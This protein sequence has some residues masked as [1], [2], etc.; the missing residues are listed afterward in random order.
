V[1]DERAI[2][3]ITDSNETAV[4]DLP[5]VLTEDEAL[6]A[7]ERLMYSA[8]AVRSNYEFTVPFDYL[9]LTPSDVITVNGMLMRVDEMSLFIDGM[10]KI[11]AKQEITSVYTNIS[12][13]EAT[14]VT[15]QVIVTPG[16]SRWFFINSPSLLDSHNDAGFYFA[17]QGYKTGWV[18]VALYQSIDDGSSFNSKVSI[19]TGVIGGRLTAALSSGPVNVWD[20][21]NTVEVELFAT[22]D[23]LESVTELQALN[24]ANTALI[25]IDG[26]WEVVSF[27][28]VTGG[29]GVY[30][31]S[32]LL[33]GRKGTDSNIN[34]HAI[35]DL[36]ILLS[37]DT[38]TRIKQNIDFA[39]INL[40]YKVPSLNT[41][42]ESAAIVNFTNTAMALKC[43]SPVHIKGVRGSGTDIVITWKRRTR[44]G[45]EWR[46][47][48][49]VS[50]SETIE[51]YEV[52]ILDTPDGT[53][54]RTL[55]ATAD[56]VGCTYTTAQQ[57]TD[58][59][60]AQASVNVVVY[61]LSESVGRGTGAIATI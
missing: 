41:S 52:D 48:T 44:I 39:N 61:Q 46:D 17:A 15:D 1:G 25:G 23:T 54:L 14:F 8:W 16:P 35:N 4:I 60:S 21:T 55:T 40:Q 31:L 50:L 20:K 36:F 47:L 45:G 5:L 22:T 34:G 7:A 27:T 28:T 53:V 59:G 13:T 43:Y 10:L 42:L 2:K 24:G 57:T 19:I 58:F 51:S 29:S 26:A 33:R 3:I 30:T 6:Q 32:N 9:K 56:D 49:D 38:L 12:T 18:G 37:S 11:K